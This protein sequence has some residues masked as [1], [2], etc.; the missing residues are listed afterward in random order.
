MEEPPETT[1][2]QTENNNVVAVDGVHLNTNG[3]TIWA[4]FYCGANIAE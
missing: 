1:Y 4:K 2:E 3:Y